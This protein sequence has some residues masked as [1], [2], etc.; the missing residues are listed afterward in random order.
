M[1]MKCI[2][3]NKPLVYCLSGIF[4]LLTGLISVGCKTLSS[5]NNTKTYYTYDS[6]YGGYPTGRIEQQGNTYY[7]SKSK[8]GGYPVGRIQAK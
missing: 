1:I 5:S 8:Y 3:L 2:K 4:L 7:R 6:K